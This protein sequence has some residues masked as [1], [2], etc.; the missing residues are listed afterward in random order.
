MRERIDPGVVDQHVEPTEPSIHLAC[1]SVDGALIGHI[2]L[3]RSHSETSL[4]KRRGGLSRVLSAS[5]AED[6]LQPKPSQA[7]GN[8]KTNTSVGSSDERDAH[9]RIIHG[10]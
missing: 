7:F 2:Q 8:R 6:H 10:R 5:C 4:R 3:E 9:G 1:G